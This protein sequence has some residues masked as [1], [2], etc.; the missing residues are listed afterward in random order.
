MADAGRINIKVTP[1]YTGF[2]EDLRSFLNKMEAENKLGINVEID[3]TAK[4]TAAVD[5]FVAKQSRKKIK[6]GVDESDFKQKVKDLSDE[7]GG[8]GKIAS[9]VSS[10]II[11][12]FAGTVLFSSAITGAASLY[13]S[14]VQ[15]S[16]AAALLPAAGAALGA[17][18]T[19]LAL[20][21]HNFG[22]ALKDLDDT[23]KFNKDL[24]KLAPQAKSAAQAIMS[25]K[26]AFDS[27]QLNTQNLLFFNLSKS[28][29]DLGTN[30]IPALR[31]G[32]SSV[33]VALNGAAFEVLQFFKSAQTSSDLDTVFQNTAAAVGQ[34]GLAIA[35]LLSA[36]RDI[37]TVGSG[38]FDNLTIHAGIT[39][40]KFADFV[41]NARSSGKLF[42]FIQGG[43]DAFRS[44]GDS[45]GN[46]FSILGSLSKGLG[47][48][49]FLG[50]LQNLTG[51]VADFFKTAQG[52]SALNGLGQALKA[53]TN[54]GG[55]VLLA[56]LTQLGK[57][58]TDN[59][60]AISDFITAFGT[61]LVR[62][63]NIVGPLV[64]SIFKIIGS[65][66]TLFANIAIGV[67]AL[68]GAF[69]VATAAL[70]LFTAIAAISP[71]GWLAIA[72]AA[73]VALVVVIVLNF[74]TIKAFVISVFT[75]IGNF[76][77]SVVQSIGGFFV[78]LGQDIAGIWGNIVSFIQTQ[79]TNVGNIIQTVINFIIGLWNGYV[80]IIDAG[81]NAIVGFF[82]SLGAGISAVWSSVISFLGGVVNNIL[83]FFQ[84]L[85][86]EI[87]AYF[88][89]LPALML[90]TLENLA[91]AFG[92]IVGTILR[93]FIELP[94][95]IL[96]EMNSL[97]DGWIAFWGNLVNVFN[98]FG[99]QVI[100]FLAGLPAQIGAFFSSLGAQV[101]AIWT[102][103]WNDV[104]TTL[105]NAWNSILDFFSS[106]PDRIYLELL[107]L[108]LGLSNLFS[109]AWNA[110]KA[111]V[112]SGIDG[113]ISF[114]TTI[115]PRALQS[116]ANWGS[117]IANSANDALNRFGRSISDGIANAIAFFA[118]LPG[119][120]ITE[121]QV[122]GP[123]LLAAAGNIMQGLLNGLNNGVN[124]VLNFFKD[125][126]GHAISGF[127]SAFGIHSPSRVMRDAG[128]NIVD[129]LVV[130]VTSQAST[131]VDTMSSLAQAGI[132]AVSPLSNIAA[133]VT[134]TGTSGPG[135]T[136]QTA[137]SLIAAG[138]TAVYNVY[139]QSQDPMSIAMQTE[140][141][142]QQSARLA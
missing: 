6:I 99:V 109:D 37:G 75:A 141:L 36:F 74:G 130:G 56:F 12:S 27:I 131:F 5:E 23:D 123:K 69:Q 15:L 44:L 8:V 91:F 25:L 102:S 51:T 39:A 58:I 26:P 68:A 71:L 3:D 126:A 40:Q 32:T 13:Q 17:V 136:T 11:K 129:G 105:L 98:N 7:I 38:V 104:S 128:V 53:I 1:S 62:A 135:F 119:K 19:T 134:A 59:A 110:V 97:I 113:V 121:V 31:D 72:I 92:F 120:A 9:G 117:N 79:M 34:I 122:L 21:L 55:Q 29:K 54:I 107:S 4:A 45:I 112:K 61:R 46:I 100:L 103:T 81:I 24:Q 10:A 14:F 28:I 142:R 125:L 35:P 67:L 48:A 47:G 118:G 114:F 66:P 22:D 20:G 42:D 52:A 133:N 85:P 86:G 89:A 116:L 106:L 82:N 137:D 94:G 49:G 124:T 111:A 77:L 93:F 139:S 87:V 43:V 33:A 101:S 132:D 96:A 60:P 88:Q 65:N 50:S 64:D 95:K 108:Q 57:I 18:V 138:G 16:G 73:V 84:A 41:A 127:L 78:G 80:G 90:A 63:L 115:V 30:F 70:G 140:R 2:K 76:V 83:A